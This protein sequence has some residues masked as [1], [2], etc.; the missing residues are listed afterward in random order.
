ME[1]NVVAP[2]QGRELKHC[3]GEYGEIGSEVAPSQGRE[4][5]HRETSARQKK[6]ESLLHRGVN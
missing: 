2:S 3:V 4:L 6:D 5:K 1:L